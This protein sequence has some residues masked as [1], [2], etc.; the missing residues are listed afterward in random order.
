MQVRIAN[1]Q[2]KVT[3]RKGTVATSNIS[4]DTTHCAQM[5]VS[6][7]DE[8]DISSVLAIVSMSE[9]ETETLIA[10]L[11]TQ[12]A[13]LRSLRAKEEHCSDCGGLVAGVHACEL[14]FQEDDE[15]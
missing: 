5:I 7:L 8:Y 11:Q 12:L 14:P 10:G 3:T 2:T 1:K 6:I 4:D 13:A 9:G 15:T